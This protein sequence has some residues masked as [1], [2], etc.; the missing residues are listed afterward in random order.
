MASRP[1]W[2][3]QFVLACW[4]DVGKTETYKSVC[5]GGGVIGGGNGIGDGCCGGG[6]PGGGGDT[7]GGGW[8]D[9]LASGGDAVTLVTSVARVAFATTNIAAEVD[10]AGSSPSGAEARRAMRTMARTTSTP[11]PMAVRAVLTW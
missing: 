10:A 7:A 5:I 3:S 9:S 4:Y 6:V 1:P 11:Q 8:G 2:R